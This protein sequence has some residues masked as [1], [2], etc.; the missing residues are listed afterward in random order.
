MN[1]H[2]HTGA[3]GTEVIPMFAIFVACAPAGE[4]YNIHTYTHI[5]TH[6][7]HIYTHN[8]KIH[9]V[10]SIYIQTLS[11]YT[12]TSTYMHTQCSYMQPPHAMLRTRWY[13]H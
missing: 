1:I 12:T 2:T 4:T 10:T 8:V 6:T 7:Q 11:M 3:E 13:D 9:T 5:H